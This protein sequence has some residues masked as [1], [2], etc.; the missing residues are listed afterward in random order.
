MHADYALFV[1]VA[2]A[3]LSVVATAALELLLRPR[4]SFARPVRAWALHAGV[5]CVMAGMLTALLGNP[6]LAM[7][8]V[9]VLFL[10]LV[11]V[12][13]AKVASLGEPFVFQDYEY[14]TDMVRYPRLYIP[15]FGWG[16]FLVSVA[17]GLGLLYFAFSGAGPLLRHD[18]ASAI[19]AGVA[20]M[21]FGA[22]CVWAAEKRPVRVSFDPLGDLGALG[23]VAG[24][25][26][27][28]ALS[29]KL[30][31]VSSPFDGLDSRPVRSLRTTRKALPHMVAVQSE[32]FF[33]PR[34]LFPAIRPSVLAE[35]DRLKAQSRAWGAL[36]VPAW[37]ANTVRSEFSFL[38]GIDASLLGAHRFNP[39]RALA[40][41]WKIATLAAFLRSLGYRTI[42]IHPYFRS[43]YLRDKVM[44]RMGFDAFRGIES[45]TGARC[46]GPYISDMAVADMILET[47]KTA[48]VPTFIFAITMENHGPLHLE[49]VGQA[50]E[51]ELYS[52]APP[53][54]FED[55]TVFLRHV[56]SA[57]AMIGTLAA[58]AAACDR[59][60][61]LCWYGDH[62]PIM[63]KVY[64][65]LGKPCGDVEYVLWNSGRSGAAA[66]QDAG[67]DQLAMKWLASAGLIG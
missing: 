35:Y 32:S 65:A 66:Y 6:W 56:R 17:G 64:T 46:F 55:L 16:N 31:E 42:C 3:I 8:C 41:G 11:L 37:G 67:V 19:P 2:A 25:W 29:R 54:N 34:R 28:W 24:L 40:R 59:P 1:P 27:Y 22:A 43:F 30:P 4:P 61:E 48:S 39:Y 13:N 10:I 63:P 53:E 20:C 57:D 18:W 9:V 50:D 21:I 47:L 51:G 23:F 36:R 12:N 5:V 7:G 15:F 26:R 60:M 45:F 38:S 44:P 33:D 49:T 58:G 52:S 62:V 14:F